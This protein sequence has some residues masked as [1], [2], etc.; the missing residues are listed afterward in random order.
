VRGVSFWGRS[1]LEAGIEVW[2]W[3]RLWM[4]LWMDR[5]LGECEDEVVIVMDE[6]ER[7]SDLGKLT[8]A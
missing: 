6:W 1:L 7:K 3:M 2:G 5:W 8:L 4:R